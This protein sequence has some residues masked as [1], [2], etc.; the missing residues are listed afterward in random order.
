[1]NRIIFTVL[2]SLLLGLSNVS[3]GQ[4]NSAKVSESEQKSTRYS[5]FAN[6][7]GS[8]I[9]SK[10][11]RVGQ[12]S[13]GHTFEVSA[14]TVWD[15]GS[16]EKIYAARFAGLII[17]YDE[18]GE[19]QRELDKIIQTVEKSLDEQANTSMN[20]K[21]LNG[22]EFSSFVFDYSP[23]NSQRMLRLTFRGTMLASGSMRSVLELRTLV[24]QVREK[25]ISLGAK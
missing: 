5:R 21:A 11:Y 13:E 2:L 14:L 18:L 23:G 3:R 15:V 22:L 25:L 4:E 17:D 6:R 8:F 9:L 24:T 1:M 12:H 16:S 20:Y 19:L 7:S 10:T